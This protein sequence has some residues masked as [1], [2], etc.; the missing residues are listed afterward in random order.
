MKAVHL[1]LLA[2]GIVLFNV[3]KADMDVASLPQDFYD[4]V[5]LYS[6]IDMIE[7]LVVLENTSEKELVIAAETNADSTSDK[8]TGDGK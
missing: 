5:D 2:A 7:N 6:K 1:F 3:S 8:E 4:N